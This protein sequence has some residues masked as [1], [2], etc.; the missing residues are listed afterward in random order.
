ML[1]LIRFLCVWVSITVFTQTNLF[2]PPET[3]SV[4]IRQ[5][6][7]TYIEHITDINSSIKTESFTQTSSE[8]D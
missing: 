3:E 4:V 1:K 5:I 8:S 6:L 7:E 2:P